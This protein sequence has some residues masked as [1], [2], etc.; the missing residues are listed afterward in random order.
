MFAPVC[1]R[2]RGYGPA[3]ERNAQRYM[4]TV[5]ALPA[6]QRWLREAALEP[7]TVTKYVV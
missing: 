1:V 3:L 7:Q 5:F 4:D 2:F 6:M